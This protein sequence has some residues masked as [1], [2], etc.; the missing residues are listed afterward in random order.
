MVDAQQGARPALRRHRDQPGVARETVGQH[1]PAGEVGL[2]RPDEVVVQPGDQS[3]NA[4]VLPGG[5][6]AVPVPGVRRS[7]GGEQ[8]AARD[9][10]ARSHD[11]EDHHHQPLR[12][13][14][15]APPWLTPVLDDVT[16]ARRRGRGWQRGQRNDDRFM[17]G[18]RRT[19][20]PHRRHGSPA[21]P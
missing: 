12:V 8:A 9:Q 7:P 18:S 17:N 3:T 5:R 20:V 2:P 13:R 1:G 4:V 11:R 19:S 14:Q 6:D 16:H 10:D 15:A 21:R